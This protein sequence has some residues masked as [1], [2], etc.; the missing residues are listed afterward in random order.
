[1]KIAPREKRGLF[2]C[3][4][5]F[6]RGLRFAHSTIPEE[7]W[8]TSRSLDVIGLLNA[9]F[10]QIWSSVAD[11]DELWV[12]FQPVRIGDIFSMNNNLPHGLKLK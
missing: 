7:K 3:G 4:V 11:Y 2:S 9:K 12:C 6:T 5:I 1:M 8:G 10:F